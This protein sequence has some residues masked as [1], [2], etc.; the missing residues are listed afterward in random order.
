MF[1]CP[2]KKESDV[3]LALKLF[4][5]DV[6]APEDLVT[7]WARVWTSDEVRNVVSILVLHWK[8]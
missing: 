6:G 8:H 7:N 5:K 1:V 4:A 3:L 2:M